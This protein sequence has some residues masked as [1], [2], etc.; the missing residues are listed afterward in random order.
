V[1]TGGEVQALVRLL[2]VI[3]LIEAASLAANYA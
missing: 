1:R 3:L 2:I